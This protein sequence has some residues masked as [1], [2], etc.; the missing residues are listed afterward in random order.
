MNQ[1]SDFIRSALVDKVARNSAYSLR[2]LARDLGVSHTYLSLILNNKKRIS[3]HQAAWFAE[4]LGFTDDKKENFIR[5]TLVGTEKRTRKRGAPSFKALEIE[6]L[7][8][9]SSWYHWAILELT[10]LKNFQPDPL[11]IA[12]A[13]GVSVI[14]IQE[15]IERLKSLKLLT[16]ENGKWRKTN[17][18]L[19]VPTTRSHDS[20][21]QLHRQFILKALKNLSQSQMSEFQRRTIS[22]AMIPCD[23]SKV[24]EAKKRVERFRRSLIRF[25]GQGDCTG[26]YQLNVQLF[27]LSKETP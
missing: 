25:L 13:I 16:I 24:E 18:L 7:K 27:P 4:T 20:I 14:S 26:L 23:P 15:A 3:A 5:S 17:S 11:W 6:Q 21:R 1:P 19:C 8:C 22:A 9:L 12:K 10:L 2:A